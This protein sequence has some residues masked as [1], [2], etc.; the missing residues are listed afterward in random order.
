MAQRILGL[1]LGVAAVK[2]VLLESA[3]R[4]WTLVDHGSAPVAPATEGGP[5]HPARLGAAVQALLAGEAWKFDTAVVAFPGAAVSSHQVTL[6]FTDSRRIAEA[7]GFEVEGLIPFDLADVAWDWQPLGTRD[8]K[9]ELLVSVV[10]KGELAGLLAALQAAGVDPRAVVPAGPALQGLLAAGA[11][12]TLLGG[13]GAEPGEPAGADVV[14]DVGAERTTVSVGTADGLEAART[15]PF[16]GAHL[17]RA[18]AAELGLAPADGAAILSAE[19]RG[20]RVPLALDA[21]AKD[22]RAAEAVR[23]ALVPLVREL[24]ATLRAWRA[25]AGARPARR[26]LLA[27]EAGRLPGLAELLVPEADGPVAPLELAGP[28]E[29]LG[30]AAGTH[31]LALALALRGLLGAKAGR[32]NLRRGDLAFTRDFEHVRGKVLKLAA[33]ASLVALLWVAGSAVEAF[34][35]ARREAVVDRALC[36]AEQSLL[37]KCYDDWEQAQSVLKGRGSPSAAL[38]KVA[39]VEIL[40]ELSAKV[41]DTVPVRFDRVEITREK[42]H[43]Q[44]TT[45][46]AEGVDKLVAALQSSRCFG[47]ARSGGARR[48]G[49]DSKFEFSIDSS[50][51]CLE[52]GPEEKKP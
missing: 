24:R 25:R 28:A 16:G 19:A 14:L 35:L 8:G 15:F 52:G 27:G 48:R 20:E 18:L 4:G 11:V 40:A 22:P 13:S 1:D 47:D 32:T 45:D 51:T 31:A 29:A 38:P 23:R 21:A 7:I 46:A 43:L 36:D 34:A 50:L 12:P 44:G 5:D 30:P 3:Y 49:S 33:W 9:T 39:A 2:G 17:A 10:K 6:P 42:L 37:G 41:P 26:I